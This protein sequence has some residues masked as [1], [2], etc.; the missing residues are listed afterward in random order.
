MLQMPDIVGY[1]SDILHK[2][3][4]YF[5][6]RILIWS[7][8]AYNKGTENYTPDDGT[9]GVWVYTMSDLSG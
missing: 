4:G 3:D 2:L 1:Q 6:L 7:R 9:Y 5:K 8:T